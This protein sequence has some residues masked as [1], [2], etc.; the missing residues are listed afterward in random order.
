M[1]PLKTT[2]SAILITFIAT[3]GLAG[4][5]AASGSIVFVKKNDVWIADGDGGNQHRLTWDGSQSTPYRSP[6]Q[7]DDGTIA[8]GYGPEILRLRPNGDLIN[9]IDPP[10][11]TNSVSHPM[12]GVP[13]DVAISPNGR[14]IAWSFVG[15]ECDWTV[16]CGVRTATGYT[17]ARGRTPVSKYGSTFFHNPS[18]AGNSRTIQGGGYGSQVMLHDLGKN[19]VHWFDDGDY[20]ENSTDLADSELS[21]DGARL[22]SVRGYGTDTRII[23]FDVSGNAK[24]GAVPPVPSPDCMSGSE[25]GIAGPTWAPDGDHLAWQ[26]NDGI[27]TSDMSNCEDS[28]LKLA[29]PGGTEPDWGPAAND[30]GPGGVGLGSTSLR[31]AI[32]KGVAIDFISTGKAKVRFRVKLGRKVVAADKGL[33]PNAGPMRGVVKFRKSALR[34]L[35]RLK[36]VRLS[37]SVSQSGKTATGSGILKR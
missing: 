23:T 37:I 4:S 26:S 24:T 21:A 8:V 7:A 36:K 9:R 27:W 2:L 29:I 19:P 15:Y 18:W 20:A 3:L 35:R 31:R 12:D 16:D 11:L 25:E 33:A 6:S 14:I 13:I 10:A 5:A 22:A 1:N 34:Q 32:R 30:P 28:G 17:D